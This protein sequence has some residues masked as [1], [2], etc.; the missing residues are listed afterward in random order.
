[1]RKDDK[2]VFCQYNSGFVLNSQMI[3]SKIIPHN[4][5][6]SE[7]KMC[8]I[9]TVSAVLPFNEEFETIWEAHMQLLIPCSKCGRKFFPGIQN[10]QLVQFE[11]IILI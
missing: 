11:A 7:F 4:N 8:L 9:Q 1:L 10:C 2:K 3:L 5:K 6:T